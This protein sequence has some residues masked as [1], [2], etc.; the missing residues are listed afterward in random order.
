[1]QALQP[2]DD[3]CGIGAAVDE[4]AQE[5]DR[6]GLDGAVGDVVFDATEKLVDEIEPGSP[7]A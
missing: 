6:R 3:P 4:I 7:S 2:L 5:D 1:M